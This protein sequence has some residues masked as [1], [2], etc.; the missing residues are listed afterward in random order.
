MHR[1]TVGGTDLFQFGFLK[2]F[3]EQCL[4][5]RHH[6]TI[7]TVADAARALRPLAGPWAELIFALGVVGAGLLAVPVLAGSS[8]FALAEAFDWNGTLDA[9]PPSAIPFYSVI[10]AGIGLGVVAD[11]MR[12]D[13]VWALYWSAVVNG[14]VAIPLLIG[15][16]L[17]GNRADLM[18]RW[19]NG[20]R[21]QIWLWITIAL[22]TVA[23]IGVVLTSG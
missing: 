23:A 2:Q 19:C 3:R 16:V 14:F 13:A 10:V 4:L 22:M 8:A 11:L 5:F 6:V 1:V 20:R 15:I 18:G 12:L 7:N 17:T 9:K 21:S